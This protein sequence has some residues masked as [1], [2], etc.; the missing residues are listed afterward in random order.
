MSLENLKITVLRASKPGDVV[1]FNVG[2]Q[3]SL[4]TRGFM[5]ALVDYLR[6]T[7]IIPVMLPDSIR[8]VGSLIPAAPAPISIGPL[9]DLRNEAAGLA[10]ASVDGSDR[11]RNAIAFVVRRLDEIIDGLFTQAPVPSPQTADSP[12]P[13]KTQPTDARDTGPSAG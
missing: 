2:E 1:F 8:V 12:D 5:E 10:R 4:E 9:I 13:E 3:P 7:G 11:E 6:P